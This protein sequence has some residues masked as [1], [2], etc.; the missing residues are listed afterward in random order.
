[1]YLHGSFRYDKLRL[2]GVTFHVCS[3]PQQEPSPESKTSP[4]FETLNPR[5]LS[6]TGLV[7]QQPGLKSL[8]PQALILEAPFPPERSAGP[9][10]VGMAQVRLRA[11]GP[12][13]SSPLLREV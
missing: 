3:K 5:T 2:Q 1:M 13:P 7:V 12:L 9:G 4:K 11:V 6:A 8:T 10:A